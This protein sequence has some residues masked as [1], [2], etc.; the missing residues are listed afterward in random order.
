[1]PPSKRPA[2][3]RTDDAKKTRFVEPGEDP[4]RFDEEVE[5]TLEGSSRAKRKVDGAGY[6]SDSSDD[7]ESVV[8][9]RAVPD[10]A[11]DD[12]DEDM[13][14][15][16]DKAPAAA[17][18]P[19]A[20]KAK[21][22]FM[23]LGDIEGQEFNDGGS[24]DGSASAPEDDE[25]AAAARAK[26]GMGF[27]LSSFNMR[28]ELEEGKFT[29]DGAYVRA[30][31]AHAQHDRWL[32]GLDARD[33]KRA[34]RRKRER[35]R[36]EQER[37]RAEEQALAD[38]GGAPALE[39]QLLALLRRGESVLEAL[40][41]F[42]AAA[43]RAKK[44]Y[45]RPPARASPTHADASKAKAPAGDADPIVHMTHL[46]S[47]LMA[48][49]D[50]DIY[51]RTHEELVRAVRKA[52]AVPDDWVAPNAEPRYEYVWDVP[53]TTAPGQVLGPYGADEM[54]GWHTAGFFGPGADKIRV[55]VVG[56]DGEWGAWDDVVV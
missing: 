53:D 37:V 50:T 46:A 32:D 45:V 34:R 19:A 30:F 54:R 47:T 17:A 16:G 4:A 35:E 42:G 20:G 7:G 55:R 39:K 13:F 41:R 11:A 26:A 15:V 28:E 48:L 21:D 12:D 5:A 14:A 44:G 36:A 8:R 10:A 18:A 25:D 40:Q 56:G 24:S 29:Q 52:G 51:S 33:L 6:D 1:M 23:R 38:A 27:A 49:G 2:E 31:D 43:K 22:D 3:A 9:S